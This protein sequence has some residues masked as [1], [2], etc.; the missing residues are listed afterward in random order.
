MMT[1]DQAIKIGSEIAKLLNLKMDKQE[2]Y[3]TSWGSKTAMGLAHCIDR[4]IKEYA[5]QLE[6]DFDARNE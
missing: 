6:L 4:I 1:N 5:G 2:R 3:T